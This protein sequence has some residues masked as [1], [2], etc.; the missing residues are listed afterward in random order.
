MWGFALQVSTWIIGASLEFEKEGQKHFDQRIEYKF[1]RVCIYMY[2]LYT[3]LQ[4]IP[5]LNR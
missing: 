3:R 5:T 4:F 1:G 2:L